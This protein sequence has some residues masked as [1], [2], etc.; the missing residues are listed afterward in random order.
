MITEDYD[1]FEV[2]KL[3][4][5]KGF[6]SP[7]SG[8]Y[9]V[10]SKEFHLDCTKMCNNGGLFECA[11]PTHQMAMKWLRE[12]HQLHISVDVSPIYGKVKDEKGR[13]TCGLLYWYYMASGEWVNEKYNPNQK[14]FVVSAKSYEDAV[15]EALKYCLGKLRLI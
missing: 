13:N 12:V 8:R 1:S 4:R 3:L 2:A 10:R 5:E 6:D 7:C 15:E 9:S 11:A 14:A